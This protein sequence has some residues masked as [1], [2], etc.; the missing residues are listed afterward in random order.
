MAEKY[1]KRC[2]VLCDQRNANQNDNEKHYTNQS[3]SD[4]ILMV[5]TH[6]GKDVVNKELSSITGVSLENCQ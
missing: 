2:F 6:G 1:L 4:Q 5:K 3:G